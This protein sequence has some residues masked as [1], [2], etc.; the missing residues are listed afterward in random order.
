[1]ENIE[2]IHKILGQVQPREG[3]LT[4]L[5]TVPSNTQANVNL[6]I[7]N[8]SS[9]P[10]KV[11]IALSKN[12]AT[13]NV[14]HCIAYDYSVP[15]ESDFLFFSGI[16]L[17]PND[18]IRV[19]SNLGFISFTADGG[20]TPY[21]GPPPPTAYGLFGWGG[22]RHRNLGLD[23]MI[24]RSYPVQVGGLTD[25]IDVNAGYHTTIALKIDG[26]LWS[27]GCEFDGALGQGSGAPEYSSPVQIGSDDV[28]ASIV[29]SGFGQHFS[30]AIGMD[31]TLWTWG[32][33]N[34]DQLGIGSK[35]NQSWPV[36]VGLL[37]NWKSVSC[38]EFG[39]MVAVKTDGTLWSWGS[40]DS[41]QLGDATTIDKSSPV[42]V[43]LLT[44]WESVACGYNHTIAVKTDGTLWSFGNNNY[45][46]LGIGNTIAKSSP[47]QVGLNSN[48]LTDWASV[49]CGYNHSMVIK[50]N[51]TLWA[52]GENNFGQLGIGSKLT[53]SWPVQVGS[54]NT[55]ASVSCGHYH[56]LAIKTDGTLWAWGSNDSG[57]LGDATTI[58]KSSPVQVGLLTNWKRVYCGM[59]Y[60]MAING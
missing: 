50:T 42:Q 43:G 55:W 13:Y 3:R 18:T 37:T 21:T 17:A 32:N 40:N 10:D 47:V 26:T 1:M 54:L 11:R 41:G 30:A 9:H 59:D 19:L 27:W 49:S 4:D 36:Q 12:S 33:N 5:Y 31:G 24:N 38:G 57:Q 6:R 34:H 52:F 45:G 44:N 48:Y 8:T 35:P 15:A 23:D 53:Q 2:N 56:T 46:Q 28:W 22:N 58:D 16:A 39:F 29:T 14:K 60:T 7:V 25:W 51:G 20:T